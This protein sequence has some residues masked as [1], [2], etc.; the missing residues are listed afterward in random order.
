MEGEFDYIDI[1]TGSENW[2]FSA[3]VPSTGYNKVGSSQR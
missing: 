2:E 1:Y 3:E